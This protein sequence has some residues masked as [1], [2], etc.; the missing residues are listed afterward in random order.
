MLL[1]EFLDYK[2]VFVLQQVLENLRF[3]VS[4]FLI[5]NVLLQ[6]CR[7]LILHASYLDQDNILKGKTSYGLKVQ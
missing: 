7:P 2:S 5:T 1:L 3:S 6:L 4:V